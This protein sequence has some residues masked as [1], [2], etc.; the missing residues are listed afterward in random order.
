MKL[1]C[2]VFVNDVLPAVRAI[3]AKDL[4]EEHG[5]TQREAARR[6]DMTQPA[7]SQYKNKLR[8]RRVKKI[9]SSERVSSKIEVLVEDVAKQRIDMEEYDERFCE[10]CEAARMDSILESRFSCDVNQ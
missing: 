4:V 5:L 2:E 10:I 8:G 1:S 3:L 9:E 7:V 6:L